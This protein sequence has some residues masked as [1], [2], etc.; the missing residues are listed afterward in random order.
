MGVKSRDCKG[1]R[2]PLA[3][4]SDSDTVRIDL[5]L[6]TGRVK[7]THAVDV[8]AS[9]VIVVRVGDALSHPAGGMPSRVGLGIGALARLATHVD[10][11]DAVALQDPPEIL[12]DVPLVPAIPVIE[13][14]GRALAVV[15]AGRTVR[16]DKPPAA[17]T[18]ARPTREGQP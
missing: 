18:R 6:G 16:G 5:R 1:Q 11:Q 17:D 10:C 8:G 15:G 3:S 9:I 13:D 7:R 4:T 14:H 12:V 2:T